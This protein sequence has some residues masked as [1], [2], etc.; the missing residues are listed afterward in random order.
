MQYHSFVTQDGVEVR[1]YFTE[2]MLTKTRSWIYRGIHYHDNWFEAPDGSEFRTGDFPLGLQGREGHRYRVCW[3]AA[4]GSNTQY[5][6]GAANLDTNRYL[7]RSSL[8]TPNIVTRLKG[9]GIS[10]QTLFSVLGA[11]FFFTWLLATAFYPKSALGSIEFNI[12]VA[13]AGV[14]LFC[15]LGYLLNCL[16]KQ[17]DPQKSF[18]A[19]LQEEL[20]REPSCIRK[21]KRY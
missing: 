16:K 18:E 6:V 9:V 19:F 15:F 8:E 3:A 4:V 2:Q 7:L 5:M 21:R 1:Y 14:F 17:W 11:I 12:W 10:Y 20:F 13:L